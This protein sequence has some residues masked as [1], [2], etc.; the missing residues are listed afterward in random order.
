MLE[1]WG[2]KLEIELSVGQSYVHFPGH[3][4]GHVLAFVDSTEVLSTV[5]DAQNVPLEMENIGSNADCP[6]S[7]AEVDYGLS[8]L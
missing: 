6:Q 5:V 8:I 4:T 1:S 2:C 7:V 3:E